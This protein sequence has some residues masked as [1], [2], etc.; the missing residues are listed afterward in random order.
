[1]SE[2]QRDHLLKQVLIN[3][4][5]DISPQDQAIYEG[6]ANKIDQITRSM[7]IRYDELDAEISAKE[8][9]TLKKKVVEFLFPKIAK[10]NHDE[11]SSLK[12]ERFLCFR[13]K[14][15]PENYLIDNE[16]KGETFVE[17]PIGAKQ[18]AALKMI[19]EKDNL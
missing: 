4:S 2:E 16:R 15:N 3:F 17:L 6:Y 1:M 19:V 8:K 7:S 13:Y 11:L 18:Y 12:D 14:K 10:K 5:Q 9:T